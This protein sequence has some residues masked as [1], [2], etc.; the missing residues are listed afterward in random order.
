[1]TIFLVNYGRGMLNEI[2]YLTVNYTY[3]RFAYST[4]RCIHFDN[5]ILH[6]SRKSEFLH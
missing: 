5:N 3:R 4:V 1:M 6:L 2:Q